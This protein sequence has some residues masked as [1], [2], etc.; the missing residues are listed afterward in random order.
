MLPPSYKL[1]VGGFKHVFPFY[2][3]DVI[4]PIDEHHHFSRWLLHHQPELV[5]NF[6]LPSTNHR[7]QPL[8]LGVSERHRPGAPV[9]SFSQVALNAEG[10]API[11]M[12]GTVRTGNFQRLHFAKWKIT[13]NVVPPSVISWFI[14]HSRYSYIYHKP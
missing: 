4:L 5:L 6:M 10:A 8:L 2:I 3:W 9:A 11:W 12:H 13:C 14:N 1:L 7:F